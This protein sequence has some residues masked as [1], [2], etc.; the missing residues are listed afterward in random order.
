MKDAGLVPSRLE[1][2]HQVLSGY[3]ERQEI[4]GLVALVSHFFSF[5]DELLLQRLRAVHHVACEI[6]QAAFTRPM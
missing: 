1:R 5:V 4:P 2:M 3:V 6:A